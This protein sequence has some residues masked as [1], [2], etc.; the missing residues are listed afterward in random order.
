[1]QIAALAALLT[2]CKEVAEKRR[3]AFMERC[4]AAKFLP[5]QCAFLLTSVE[6]ASSDSAAAEVTANAMA[7]IQIMNSTTR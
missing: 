1:M 4:A 5:E 7:T 2:G 3:V 6:Q